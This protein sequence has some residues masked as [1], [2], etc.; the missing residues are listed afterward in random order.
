LEAGR[1]GPLGKHGYGR[2]LEESGRIAP[3]IM[4]LIVNG[5]PLQFATDTAASMTVADLVKARG[6]S[7]ALLAIEVN[8][9]IVPRAKHAT[10]TLHD[11]DQVEI[12]TL[13]GG[14]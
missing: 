4:N 13:A 9:E 11:G 14:G 5:K 6:L 2:T 10:H 7:P 1:N 12:V 3:Y 8:L